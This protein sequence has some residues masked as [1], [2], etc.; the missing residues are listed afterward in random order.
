[1]AGTIDEYDWAG[2]DYQSIIWTGT[3]HTN[4][5]RKMVEPRRFEETMVVFKIQNNPHPLFSRQK[6]ISGS[7]LFTVR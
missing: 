3:K 1:M 4:E 2:N 7:V 5:H 6:R